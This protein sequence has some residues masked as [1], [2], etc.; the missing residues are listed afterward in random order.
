LN[1]QCQEA[2]LALARLSNAGPLSRLLGGLRQLFK[3]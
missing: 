2:N 1:P 3:K